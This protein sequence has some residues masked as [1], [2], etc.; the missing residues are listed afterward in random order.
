MLGFL[1]FFDRRPKA[2]SFTFSSPYWASGFYPTVGVALASNDLRIFT[3]QKFNIEALIEIVEKRKVTHLFAPP[4][5]LALILHS[6]EFKMCDHTSLTEIMSGGSA[7]SPSLREKFKETFPDKTL[8]V[9]YG[10][11]EAVVTLL[12]NSAE[13]Q[14]VAKEVFPNTIVKVVDD[15]GNKLGVGEPGELCIKNAFKFLVSSQVS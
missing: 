8:R 4:A 15:E 3:K 5:Q 11:T 10:M 2:I 6:D 9:G 7:V 14:I 13:G 1:P 12:M